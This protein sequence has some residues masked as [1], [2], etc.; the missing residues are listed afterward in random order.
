VF[1]SSVIGRV[2]GY[3]LDSCVSRYSNWIMVERLEFDS[4]Q[5]NVLLSLGVVTGCVL[6]SSVTRYSNW[7]R[8]G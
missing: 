7:L 2:I 1:D 8:V 5:R 6:D 4:R 3:V